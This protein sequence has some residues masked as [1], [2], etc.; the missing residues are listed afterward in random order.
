MTY[1][2][3]SATITGGWRM[4]DGSMRRTS[5]VFSYAVAGCG[6]RL[7]FPV[8][9]GDVVEY[10]VL[11]AGEPEQVKVDGLSITDGNQVVTFNEQPKEVRLIPGYSSGSHPVITRARATFAAGAPRNLEVMTCAAPPPTPAG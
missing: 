11:A 9:T 10:D 4:P 6:V 3:K 7:R 5:T 8:A 1:G 2:P